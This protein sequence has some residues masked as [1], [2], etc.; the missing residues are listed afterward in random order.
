M[1]SKFSLMLKPEVRNLVLD[2]TKANYFETIV[3]ALFKIDILEII[4]IKAQLG[5]AFHIQPSEIDKMS[6][7]ELEFYLKE[8]EKL[9]KEENDA[10]KDELEKS[11]AS[12]AMKMAD[13]NNMSKM[14][15][16]TPKM[17]DMKM[18]NI[19]MKMPSF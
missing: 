3:F 9:V 16:S 12:R 15:S 13:P 14:M 5:K 17:P 19:N 7:W 2:N 10:N 11:G 8:L 18:P 6:F 4:N 1:A